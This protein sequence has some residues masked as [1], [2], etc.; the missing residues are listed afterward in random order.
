[1]SQYKGGLQGE[2]KTALMRGDI[3]EWAIGEAGG[4]LST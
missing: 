1:M 3:C 4:R 2:A